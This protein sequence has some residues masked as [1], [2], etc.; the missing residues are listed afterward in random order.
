MS[1]APLIYAIFHL[2]LAFSS[3]PV[4]QRAGVIQQCYWPLLNLV[5]RD[6]V[7]L[8]FEITAFTL[9]EIQRL[10]PGWIE[11]LRQ[12]LA[13]NRCEL[14]AS[15]DTQLIGPLV[16][17]RV[18]RW[19]I[20]LG[21]EAYKRILDYVPKL[22]YINEQAVSASLLDLYEEAGYTGIV[23][24]WDNSRMLHP[25]WGEEPLRHPAM[26][27]TASG[28]TIPVLWNWSIAFQKFQRFAH[29]ELT[30]DDYLGFFASEEFSGI[31]ALSIY[32]NDAEIFDFRPGR[33]REEAVIT[34][35]E[36]Q[37]IGSLLSRL[38]ES[39]VWGLPYQ[40]LEQKIN[41]ACILELTTPE[42][43]IVVKKQRKY[44]LTRWA[45]TGRE[46]L[47]LNTLCFQTLKR[48]EANKKEPSKKE[49]RELCRLWASDYRTHL[50]QARFESLLSTLPAFHRAVEPNP[51][52][53][54][55]SERLLNLEGWHV[56]WDPERF[57]LHLANSHL[58]LILNMRRGGAIVDL[59]FQGAGS[60]T[61]TLEHGRFR[62][63]ELG[64]D[65]YSFHTVIELPGERRRVT[66]L[67][68]ARWAMS[69]DGDYPGD[70]YIDCEMDT[71]LGRVRKTYSVRTDGTVRCTWRFPDWVRP[72][73]SLRLGW[74][75][76]KNQ[77]AA[78]RV[79]VATH[80]G[81]DHME[82][83][84]ITRDVDHGRAVSSVVSA[85]SALGGTEGQLRLSA[86]T[87]GVRLKWAPDQCA[88][89]PM[90]F[91]RVIGAER[92]TRV[93]FSLVEIDDTLRSGG[94]LLP[95][96]LEISPWKPGEEE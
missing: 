68:P 90:L 72:E 9:E 5:Q 80:H 79:M 89:I 20:E 7:P 86:G 26:A 52:L 35:L 62:N 41:S 73:G 95:F 53:L 40:V 60:D 56:H 14:I 96:T 22:A 78:A 31:R 65:Y 42:Y 50:E 39:N 64:A 16:P 71:Y 36:W 25:E 54:E 88:A 70:I 19:N 4:N 47:L 11:L 46:D 28:K 12:L 66:D 15:G 45:V 84:A 27:Q 23:M 67:E 29:S 76:L 82:Y 87:Q 85:T 63:I 32:G 75:T 43:P 81:G 51:A 37:R 94:T 69:S 34:G 57:Y 38:G 49:R 77:D 61:G 58:K 55:S 44:N 13:E 17:A 2:N 91:N 59:A 18:N 92:L 30:M 33:Y 8:G 3:I 1:S 74:V 83:G 6:G 21:T 10:D 93:F 48:L 24:E